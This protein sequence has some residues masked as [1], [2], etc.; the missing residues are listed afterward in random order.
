MVDATTLLPTARQEKLLVQTVVDELVVYE[1]DR[2]QAHRLN[3]IAAAVWRHCDGHTT[4]SDI[5]ELVRT[6]TQLPI[7]EELVWLALVRLERARLLQERVTA[8][9]DAIRLAR[10]QFIQKLGLTAGLVFLLPVVESI[11]IP[12]LVVGVQ[13]VS[14]ARRF[15]L[16]T[17]HEAPNRFAMEVLA[18]EPIGYWRLNE[19]PGART[20]IDSSGNENHGKYSVGIILG[21][22]GLRGGDTAAV[23]NSPSDRIIVRDNATLH[24]EHITIEAYLKWF[25]DNGF[26]QTIVEKIIA[27]RA[28]PRESLQTIVEQIIAHRASPREFLQTTIV[29]QIIA[30]RASPPVQAAYSLTILNDGRIQVQI[31]AAGKPRIVTSATVLEENVPTHL[32]ATYNGRTIEI[33]IDGILDTFDGFLDVDV[34][35]ALIRP[36]LSIGPYDNANL[37]IG[38]EVGGK[39]P[40]N[41]LIDEIALYNRALAP[42]RIQT[43]FARTFDLE[44]VFLAR[45][46]PDKYSIMIDANCQDFCSTNERMHWVCPIGYNFSGSCQLP[47]EPPISPVDLCT[48]VGF[49]ERRENPAPRQPP[50]PASEEPPNPCEGLI[51]RDYIDCLEEN[52]DTFRD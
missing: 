46:F 20:A 12:R 27:H 23:F 26:Q 51:G 1:Q 25:G 29:E 8:T 3:R 9:S 2:H 16:S 15:P 44:G 13:R 41:G 42:E 24:P 40:F 6:E 4:I 22:P 31:T 48:L 39:R 45:E 28:S 50:V 19:N 5:T 38:N 34:S 21:Q 52:P 30:H 49:C 7:D 35:A 14:P 10:R 43:H 18:D 33:Y 11:A 36:V 32:V 37:G 47:H 17:Q